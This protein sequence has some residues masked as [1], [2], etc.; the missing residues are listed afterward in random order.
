ML[1]VVNHT[2]RKLAN[3][4]KRMRRYA[5]FG[6]VASGAKRP[7]AVVGHAAGMVSKRSARILARAGPVAPQ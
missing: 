5:A 1:V 4:R 6:G 2:A 7:A 3:K